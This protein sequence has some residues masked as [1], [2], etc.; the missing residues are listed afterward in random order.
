MGQLSEIGAAALRDLEAAL[1]V[2]DL[3]AFLIEKMPEADEP[4]VMAA[5]RAAYAHGWRIEPA[6]AEP[7]TYQLGGRE[8]RACAQRV[9][10]DEPDS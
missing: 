9:T 10:R 8:L 5:L 7:R 2:D 3:M 6:G 4:E 1:P